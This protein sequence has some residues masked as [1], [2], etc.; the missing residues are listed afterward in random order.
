M[1]LQINSVVS[2]QVGWS[3]LHDGLHGPEVVPAPDR[4]SKRPTVDTLCTVG[5]SGE[6][7]IL[8]LR[9]ICAP[10][11]GFELDVGRMRNLHE[12]GLLLHSQMNH[13]Y[14]ACGRHEYARG[15]EADIPGPSHFVME[16]L[17]DG[18]PSLHQMMSE[19]LA[20][21]A[22]YLMQAQHEAKFLQTA[23]LLKLRLHSLSLGTLQSQSSRSFV[24][25]ISLIFVSLHGAGGYPRGSRKR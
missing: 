23:L 2:T 3:K 16:N 11:E 14:L 1:C 9:N 15:S 19:R 8:Q 20:Q 17:E 21:P 5:I 10:G 4:I 7:R 12:R 24:L 25:P 22:S 6:Q 13:P 18:F